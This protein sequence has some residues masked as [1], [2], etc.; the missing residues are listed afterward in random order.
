MI[1]IDNFK[2]F[3]DEHGHHV[4]DQ[5]LREVAQVLQQQTRGSDVAARF[6]GEEFIVVL[7]DIPRRLALERAEQLRSCVENLALTSVG[8]PGSVTISIGLAEFPADG[9]TLEALLRAADKA[10]YEAKRAGRNRVVAA[11]P[12]GAVVPFRIAS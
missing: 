12:G 5:V 6:G 7:A 8:A 3:N 2:H 1:D 4:G 9:N 11:S 10:P